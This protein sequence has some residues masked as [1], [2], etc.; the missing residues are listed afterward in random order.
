M[1]KIGTVSG[2]SRRM[3]LAARGLGREASPNVERGYSRG[4]DKTLAM[5]CAFLYGAKRMG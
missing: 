2:K 3:L 5:P 1:E 4:N